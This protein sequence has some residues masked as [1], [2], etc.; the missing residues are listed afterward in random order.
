MI[1][2][3]ISFV[4]AFRVASFVAALIELRGWVPTTNPPVGVLLPPFPT[5]PA[6]R[7]LPRHAAAWGC[8]PTSPRQFL[9]SPRLSPP[10]RIFPG[11]LALSI[12]ECVSFCGG[13]DKRPVPEECLFAIIACLHV[14]GAAP[15]GLTAFLGEE[16]QEGEQ[17]KY[18][19]SQTYMHSTVQGSHIDTFT[20]IYGEIQEVV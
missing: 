20:F 16:S 11:A 10:H 7:P 2:R 17:S 3:S 14:C 13:S 9:L 8:S 12:V 5:W 19:D 1:F 4:C 18:S 15:F 6:L